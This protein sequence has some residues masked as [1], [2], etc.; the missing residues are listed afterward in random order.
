MRGVQFLAQAN[1]FFQNLLLP[2]SETHPVSYPKI[3]LG[4]YPNSKF[5]GAD[6]ESVKF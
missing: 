3:T 1:C 4:P 2:S 5:S 6:T